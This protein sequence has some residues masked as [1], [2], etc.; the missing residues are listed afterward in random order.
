MQYE[1]DKAKNEINIRKHGIDFKDA[2]DIFEHPVLTWLDNREDYGEERWIALG[3]IR[4]LTGVVIYTERHGDVVR[5]ISAR[6][7]TKL[8][9]KK[10]ENIIE[11]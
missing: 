9:R 2:K 3:V 10:Y 6:R 11:N 7:A 5:I 1:W 4:T 8:E